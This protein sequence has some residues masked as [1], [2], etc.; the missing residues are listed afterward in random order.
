MGT[1]DERLAFD[2]GKQLWFFEMMQL[3]FSLPTKDNNRDM[4]EIKLICLVVSCA[5][6]SLLRSVLHYG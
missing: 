4:G 6:G 1:A 3:D 5:R 2:L